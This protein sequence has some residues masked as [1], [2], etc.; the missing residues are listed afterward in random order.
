MAEAESTDAV[1]LAK[2]GTN[3]FHKLQSLFWIKRGSEKENISRPKNSTE[4]F[5][6]SRR[7]SKTREMRSVLIQ[8]KHEYFPQQFYVVSII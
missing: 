4:K 8:D 1:F 5:I 6:Y 3:R 7:V 2:C